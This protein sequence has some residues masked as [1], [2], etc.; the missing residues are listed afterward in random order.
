MKHFIGFGACRLPFLRTQL[1][2]FLL[3]VASLLLPAAA[4][5]QVTSTTVNVPFGSEAV[6]S[7]SSPIAVSFS[8]AAETTVGSVAVLTTGIADKDFTDAGSST[9]TAQTYAS[10]TACVV[11]VG[12]AP[13]GPGLRRGAVVISDGTGTALAI[14]PVYGNGT[15]P[16]V[17]YAPARVRSVGTGL[18]EPISVTVDSADNVYIAEIAGSV[19]KVTPAGVQTTLATGIRE[20]GGFAIDGA[21]NQ[22]IA[23]YDTGN[24]FKTTPAGV[25]TVFLTVLHAEVGGMT[26]DG[27]GNLYIASM[28]NASILK[29]SPTGVQTAIGSGFSAPFG[30]AV[31]VAGNV[32]VADHGSQHVSK[33][34]PGGVITAIGSGLGSLAAV[35]VDASGNLYVTGFLNNQFFELTQEGVMTPIAT[36]AITGAGG[37]ALDT[38]G[39][40]YYTD[41][42]SG[43]AGEVIRAVP[44]TSTFAAT[45]AGLTSTDSPQTV[46]V[47]NIGN[48]AL[49]FSAIT[50][51][52]DF[53]EASSGTD[54]C[55]G[56]TELAM[57]ANCTLTINFSPVT[58]TSNAGTPVLLSESVVIASNT[59]NVAGT[60][61][62][63][64]VT[65]T[66]EPPPSPVSFSPSTL[67]FPTTYV[68]LTSAAQTITF[69]NMG[70]TPV[71]VSSYS[72]MGANASA[73]VVLGKTCSASLAAGASCTLSIAFRP[74]AN[75]VVT[76]SLAATDNASGSP[77]MATLGGIGVMATFSVLPSGLTFDSTYLGSTS[78]S[79]MITVTNSGA[80]AA[81]VMSYTITGANASSFLLTGKTCLTSLAARTSCTVSI[82]FRPLA[83]GTVTANLV[84]MDIAVGSPQVVTLT[85]TGTTTAISLSPSSLT[86]A[87]TAVGAIAP[88]QTITVTNTG[89]NTAAVESYLFTGAN[90]TTF[91][92]RGKTCG[93]TL[94]AGASCTLSIAFQPTSGGPRTANLVA[95]SRAVGS[96]QTVTLMGTGGTTTFSLSPGS[97]TFP[98]TRVGSVSA[99]QIVTVIN[100]GTTAISVTSYVFI[101]D[102]PSSFFLSGKTCVKTLAAG[103]SCTLS[104]AFR[105]T[106]AGTA[107][108]GIA[109]TD[110]G[111]DSPQTMGLSGTATIGAPPAP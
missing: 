25:R 72:I 88:A 44:P 52:I 15:G 38:S 46:A 10:A 71:S 64:T 89:A 110:T 95:T 101:G 74:T 70:T 108:A 51:P 60:T 24:I 37:V 93:T 105:P 30:V 36:P 62:D 85:G 18:S 92:L 67:G 55:T 86:F 33:V 40:L 7:A 35:A 79:Q 75:G 9:C 4:V 77:Q 34:T 8:I 65:G 1:P 27:A 58:P 69:T 54:D 47:Q 73:F 102:D 78:A 19:F 57:A 2:L 12:F 56:S 3:A 43:T 80:S 61:Q 31:D 23:E 66:R 26:M 20:A 91:L 41:F 28:S 68:G 59:L 13:R 53:P 63:A 29:V 104:V 96:P 111:P 14:V 98:S 107:T 109:A 94:A 90:P 97:L 22:Y 32:Y 16:Q 76:A 5:A 49:D 82:A 11:N 39:N 83:G 87:T 100:T 45:P 48:A 103:A 106:A 99:S 81:A 84:A 6:G 17:S 50:Y 21:G 42:S